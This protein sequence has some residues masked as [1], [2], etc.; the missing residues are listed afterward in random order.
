MRLR[1]RSCNEGKSLSLTVLVIT[2]ER[3]TAR[4]C[5]EL[6]LVVLAADC[7]QTWERH[8]FQTRA[9]LSLGD[10]H[11]AL[12][13]AEPGSRPVWAG[14]SDLPAPGFDSFLRPLALRVSR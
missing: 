2:L 13:G 5:A 14:S 6:S 8:G 7:S 10:H 11:V 3:M 4:W 9:G 1:L 12:V